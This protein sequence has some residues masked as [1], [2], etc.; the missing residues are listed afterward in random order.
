MGS[1]G[2]DVCPYCHRP[3]EPATASEPDEV[4][5]GEA[6]FIS[7][8]YF[9]RLGASRTASQPGSRRASPRRRLVPPTSQDGGSTG[10]SPG[11]RKRPPGLHRRSETQRISSAA[12]LPDYFARF[13]VEERELGRGGRGVVLLVRHVLDG[14]S[15]G[16]FACKRI[17]V[18]DDHEWLE[19]VLME[20][21]MLQDISH[22]N[23]VSYRHVWLEDFQYN[24]FT[25]STPHVF[26]LQQYCNSGTLLEHVLGGQLSSVSKEELKERV[27]RHSR[28]QSDAHRPD[29]LLRRMSLEEIFSFFSDITKGLA[30]LHVNGFVHRDLKPQNCLLHRTGNVTRVLVSDFGEMRGAS[31]SRMSNATGYTGTVSFAAPEV[32]QRDENGVFGDFTT[33][34]DIFSLGMI[35]YF[36]GKLSLHH[37]EL[38]ADS[39]DGASSMHT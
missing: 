21:S 15:L 33:K 20:V 1:E 2:L 5:E 39:T 29:R 12:F 35:F 7:P 22:E 16:K 19:N 27:R 11:R 23:L 25:P 4:D 28:G 13:F 38:A 18:G 31:M 37:D 8:Q 32:V 30:H 36:M 17:A 24:T 9:R 6:S 3:F 26:I 14:V 10:S 34:S